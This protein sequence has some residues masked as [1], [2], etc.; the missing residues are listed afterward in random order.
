VRIAVLAD[1]HGNQFGFFAA[2]ADARKQQ[3]DRIVSAGDMLCSFPGGPQILHAL[4]SEQIPCVRGN[5]DDLML[6][7]FRSEPTSPFRSSPQF[8]PLQL[9][10]SRFQASDFQIVEQWPLSRQF[11]DGESALLVCHG[12][13][14]SST[15]S[16][17]DFRSPPVS[18]QLSRMAAGAVVAGHRH[19]QW[20]AS[21]DG[22][23]LVL[24]G[25][26]GMPCA[27][28]TDA[29]YAI[30][31]P[32]REGVR[33][34]HRSV[35]YDHQGFISALKAND[36]AQ[37]AG[38]VGWLEVSQVLLPRPLMLF[39]FRDRFDPAQGADPEYLVSSVKSHLEE[40]GAWD[41]VD[42]VFGPLDT[43]WKP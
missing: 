13:P 30:L 28:G 17:A 29:Q 24:A 40:Y 36:Y 5:A 8:R 12:A 6:E 7:W 26:C 31:D 43:G 37:R 33:V 25:S 4:R 15:Q 32:D 14:E 38:P 27:D 18:E 39:Y 22:K 21:V 9:S 11:E 34:R 1:A 16:I 42:A 20:S 19:H 3:P 2:L 23:L 35:E 10:C 41:A